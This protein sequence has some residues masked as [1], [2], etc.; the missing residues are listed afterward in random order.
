MKAQHD[1]FC[2]TYRDHANA[3]V[4][5]VPARGVMSELFGKAHRLQ[6]RAVGGSMHLFLT[7]AP[8]LGGCLN[9]R[10]GFPGG[11]RSRLHQA[12]TSAMA[13]GCQAAI[14]HAA[15]SVTALQQ[16]I[17]SYECL[18]MAALGKQPISLRG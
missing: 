3:L 5:G 9:R 2:S 14:R 13:S 17:S 16:R 8:L 4:C 11:S 1:W 10:R 15:F 6:P 12:A 7:G 18:N